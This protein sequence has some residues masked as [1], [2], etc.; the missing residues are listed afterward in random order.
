MTVR[1]PVSGRELTG[2]FGLSPSV[3]VTG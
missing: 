2:R 1:W 3:S